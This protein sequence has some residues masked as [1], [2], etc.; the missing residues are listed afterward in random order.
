MLTIVLIL[1]CIF[2]AGDPSKGWGYNQWCAE[3]AV[4]A[5]KFFSALEKNNFNAILS[6]TFLASSAQL[7]PIA[8]V[9]NSLFWWLFGNIVEKKLVAWRYPLF[10]LIG[11]V[12]SWALLVYDIGVPPS[13]RYIGPTM[14]TMYLLGAFLIFKPKKPFKPAEWKPPAWKIFKG[15]DPSERKMKVPWVSPWIYVGFFAAYTAAL[16]FLTSMSAKDLVDLTHLG[17]VGTVRNMVSG[18]ITAGTIQV[19]RP[20][21]AVEAMLLGLLS[22]YIL[23]NIVF[24]TKLRRDA[25]DLQIQAV[26]QYKELRALDMNHKQAVEGT[27]KL[28]G[29]PLDIVKDWI[30]KGLQ[31]PP[32]DD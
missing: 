22:G 8:F 7:G 32:K 19:M 4:T 11:M 6:M 9:F 2:V 27:S 28:I 10:L 3:H 5:S 20:I 15:D 13:Q 16:H 14:M 31:T 30:S 21:P 29:V 24:K 1:T 23:V 17:F 18:T 26:L 25:G 12:G